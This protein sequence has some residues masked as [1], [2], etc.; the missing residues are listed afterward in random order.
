M[1]QPSGDLDSQSGERQTQ[2]SRVES[3]PLKLP[4]S[5]AVRQINE[6]L[7]A[8]TSLSGFLPAAEN[9]LLAASDDF[10]GSLG[11]EAIKIARSRN[12]TA[13]DRQDVLDADG[14]LR[15]TAERRGWALGV[16]GLTGGGAIAATVALLLAPPPVVH[17]DYW[18]SAIVVLCALAIVLFYV[19]YPSRRRR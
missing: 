8:E 10:T 15:G 2:L 17:P 6:A 5:R 3:D 7:Q 12:A 9:T 16:A 13:V 14:G 11:I 4:P 18:W 1:T 19:S